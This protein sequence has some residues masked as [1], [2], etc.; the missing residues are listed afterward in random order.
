[1]YA[2]SLTLWLPPYVNILNLCPNTKLVS[3]VYF[4]NG[5]VCPKLFGQQIDINTKMNASFEINATQDDF[6]GALL[7]RLQRYSNDQHN[8]DTSTTNANKNELTHVYIL[9]T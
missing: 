8:T 2:I 6:E 1:M 3:S 4:G 9:A 5:I 7:F